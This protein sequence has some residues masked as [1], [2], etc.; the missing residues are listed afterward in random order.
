MRYALTFRLGRTR[1]ADVQSSDSETLSRIRFLAGYIIVTPA[2]EF[3]EAT[4]VVSPRTIALA[5][6]HGP[7]PET[8]TIAQR[9]A[10]EPQIDQLQRSLARGSERTS[11]SF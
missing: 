9:S 6:D 8:R 1:R 5:A 10:S 7:E 3:S 2:S 4:G 11:S